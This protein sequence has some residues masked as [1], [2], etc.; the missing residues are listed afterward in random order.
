MNSLR[1]RYGDNPAMRRIVL[2]AERIISDVDLLD[3]D[4]NELDLGRS[5]RHAFR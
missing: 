3:I 2:D 4:A 1:S 5:H